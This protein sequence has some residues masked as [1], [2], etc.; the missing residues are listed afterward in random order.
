VT[1]LYFA[2]EYEV[3][4]NFLERRAPFRDE[5]LAHVR[6]ARDRGEIVMAGAVGEP[7]DGALLIFKAPDAALVDAFADADPYVREQ[8]VVRR[9]VRR[10]HVVVGA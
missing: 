4:P 5:H 3:V 2:L 8:L 7:P 9:R 10:W 1:P 6:A